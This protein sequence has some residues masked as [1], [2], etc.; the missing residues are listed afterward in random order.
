M[1]KQRR[2]G[3][4]AEA[5]DLNALVQAISN[6]LLQHEPPLDDAVLALI[7]ATVEAIMQAESE[8][9]RAQ[10]WDLA[11]RELDS[12]LTRLEEAEAARSA[13]PHCHGMH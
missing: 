12:Y 2:R 5:T 6:T 4:A 7:C 11:H 9:L 13:M 10:L 1:R 3:R 8:T